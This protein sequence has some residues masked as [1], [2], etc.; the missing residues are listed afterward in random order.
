MVD[1]GP[2][3]QLELVGVAVEV[4]VVKVKALKGGEFGDVAVFLV[5]E[6]HFAGGDLVLGRFE[7]WSTAVES[8]VEIGEEP[9]GLGD[10]G[11]EQDE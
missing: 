8:E 5:T 10:E 2:H 7:D 1:P 9:V 4:G 6:D 3:K 11:G